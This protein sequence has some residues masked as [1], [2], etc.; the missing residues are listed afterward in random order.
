MKKIISVTLV[1]MTIMIILK[2]PLFFSP[3]ISNE[4]IKM[5]KTSDGSDVIAIP[6]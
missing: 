5:F 3:A 6:Y 4:R 1:Y 2:F